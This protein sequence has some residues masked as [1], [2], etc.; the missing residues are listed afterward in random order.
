MTVPRMPLPLRRLGHA[1][2][3]R[4][5]PGAAGRIATDLFSSTRGQ[6]THPDDVL[7][8]G[9]HRFE[10]RG[11]P[12]IRDGYLWGEPGQSSNGTALLV[13]GWGTD[14]SRMHGLVAP[15]RALGYRVA[16][17][18]APGHGVCA[19]TQSTMTRFA[20]ATGAVLDTLGDVRAI[21]A[22]SLGS[23]AAI[24]EAAAR[25]ELPIERLVLIAPTCTVAGALERWSRSE[26]R[27]RRPIVERVY[28][29]LH[30][31]NG[32]PVTHWDIAALGANLDRPVLVIHDPHD[33]MVPYSEA[34][35]VAGGL[36]DA[37]LEAAPG[38]GHLAILMAP[39]VKDLMAGFV[40]PSSGPKADGAGQR[41]CFTAANGLPGALTSKRPLSGT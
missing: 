41:A 5:A 7:P 15:L 31:R 16:A 23:I 14:S 22:H 10:V 40:A 3:G 25:P 11:D 30:R 24:S 18:D 35:A 37:R 39:P 33:D 20:R 32:M 12:D 36:P 38:Y 8:L 29:E 17:F 6:G 28:Q 4:I 13:H 1:A 9:A 19:G 27:L 34:E 2:L 21:V 26:L